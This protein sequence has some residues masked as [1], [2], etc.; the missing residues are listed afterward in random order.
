MVQMKI[1]IIIFLTL[2]YATGSSKAGGDVSPMLSICRNIELGLHPEFLATG[3][4]LPENLN[5]IELL[6]D[7]VRRNPQ[8]GMLLNEMAIVPGAPTISKA[9]GIPRNRLLWRIFAIG[10]TVNV[11]YGTLK[12]TTEE[13]MPGRYSVWIS[14]D[15]TYCAPGWTPELTVQAV[16]KQIGGFDPSAQPL[17]FPDA[18]R[19][20]GVIRTQKIAE[21]REFKRL[22]DQ[23]TEKRKRTGKPRIIGSVE[24][25]NTVLR[26]MIRLLIPLGLFLVAARW[27]LHRIRKKR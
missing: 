20:I 24:S 19:R 4:K 10:R 27:F 13:R 2:S 9:P 22:Y 14:P 5:E 25:E 26:W 1:F 15:G 18:E 16:F 7:D 17:P 21:D 8:A 3:R 11:D 6:R 12:T 23:R